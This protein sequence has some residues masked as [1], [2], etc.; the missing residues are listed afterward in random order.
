MY[1]AWHDDECETKA[2]F[3]A[4]L[5]ATEPAPFGYYTRI[6]VDAGGSLVLTPVAPVDILQ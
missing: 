4:C 2:D 6:T 1:T 3:E 5:S